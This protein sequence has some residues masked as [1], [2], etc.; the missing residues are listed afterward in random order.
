MKRN[1]KKTMAFLA[2]AMMLL[3]IGAAGAE[4]LSLNGTV[5]AGVTLPV[6]A[7]IGGT[8]DNVAVETGMR[9]SA[10]DILFS[11]KTE[12]IYASEDGTVT[13]VFAQ[14]G[15]DAETVTEIY[16]ADLFIEG[17]TLYTISASTSKAYSD[18]ET[19][20]VHAGEKVYIQCRNNTARIGEG[21]IV[22]VEDSSY[23]VRVTSGSFINGDSV[24]IFRDEAYSD[25]LRVGRGTIARV[26]PTAVTGTGAVVRVAVKDGDTV[27]RGDLLMETLTGTFDGYQM[28]GTEVKAE[29]DGVITSIT[30]AAGSA[31]TK[32][33]VAVEIAP[34]SGI[35]VSA[36][37]SADDRQAVKA[38]DKVQIELETDETKTYEG[39]VRWISE[40][41]EES[42][43]EVTYKVIIDFTPD[44]YAVFGMGVI[45]TVGAEAAEEASA[46]QEIPEEAAEEAAEEAPQE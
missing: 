12:K 31:L 13:G 30:A 7:P 17:K 38:G 9:V 20:F 14:P 5:E 42:E 24:A 40:V 22:A 8:V 27:K 25:K 36:K 23:T 16:G 28:T 26:S 43:E 41:A 46:P 33:D 39:T 11:Y 18:I 15:D 29:E 21:I 2:A 6:Y 44:E 1:L 10:G 37:V 19:T 3:T 34:L 32:G 35:R 4:T 45:V